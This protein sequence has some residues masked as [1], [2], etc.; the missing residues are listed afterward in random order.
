MIRLRVLASIAALIGPSACAL[1]APANTMGELAGQIAQCLVMPGDGDLMLILT[2][3]RDGRLLGT[4]H[5]EYDRLALGEKQE[6]RAEESVLQALQHCLPADIT[7]ALGKTIAGRSLKLRLT[8][9]RREV[10]I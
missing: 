7:P 6:R 10:D 1:A 5:V 2:L 3:G 8:A 4:P 9:K